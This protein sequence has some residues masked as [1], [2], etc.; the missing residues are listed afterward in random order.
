MH[1]SE[2]KTFNPNAITLFTIL[3][4]SMIILMGAA[5]IAP[6][7]KPI[8]EH[9]DLSDSFLS[10][11]VVSL[12][13]LSVAITGFFVGMIADKIGKVKVLYACLAIFTVSGAGGYFCGDSFLL[14]L[15]LRFILGIGITGI[16]LTSTALIGEYYTG[17]E[18]VRVIGLQAAAIGVGTI[19]LETAGGYLADFGWAEPFLIYLVGLPILVCAAVSVR[20]PKL[21]GARR[22]GQDPTAA[23][24]AITN[25]KLHLV[26][27]YFVV[28]M[29]MLLMF[30]LP[31]NFSFYV[32]EDLGEPYI[33]CGL[34]MG[35]M[36]IAQAVFSILY[37]RRVNKMREMQSY[38]V[39]F[40]LMGFGLILLYIP[41]LF[42]SLVSMILV[43][44]SLGLLM[45][46]VIS[47]L[48]LISTPE[49]SGKI[50]G[51]Y[52]VFL[53]L[54]NFISS[55]AFA[56]VLAVVGSY[57]NMFLTAGAISFII[58]VV[59]LL[60]SRRLEK[61][62]MKVSAGTRPAQEAKE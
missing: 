15:V 9:F 51:G 52:S 31:M 6:A 22:S 58:C 45:P 42:L 43:G 50:M 44:M 57:T 11:L 3:A 36:G 53:N 56:A 17:Q 60:L 29:E 27:C 4:S 25:K 49:T 5:A 7:I 16:S 30:S 39:A 13:S 46:T 19:I 61:G 34:L 24:P 48:S 54:S 28:F 12:P 10:S 23:A 32:S 18:C 41:N 14:L 47:T 8:S 40:V 59:V 1:N 62:N 2:R 26:I 35:L 21:M 33:F 38:F 55:I 20:D 37:S